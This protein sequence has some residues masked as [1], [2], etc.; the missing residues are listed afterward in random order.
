[1]SDPVSPSPRPV[2]SR[3][4]IQEGSFLDGKGI[5]VL[6]GALGLVM[7]VII[8]LATGVAVGLIPFR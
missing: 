3:S 7:M 5:P 1:M 8:V 2:R 6:L 4:R